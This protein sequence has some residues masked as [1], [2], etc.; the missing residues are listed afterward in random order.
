[1]SQDDLDTYTL[2]SQDDLESR[3]PELPEYRS[4]DCLPAVGSGAGGSDGVV[5]ETLYSI[6]RSQI[7]MSNQ[8]NSVGRAVA[9]LTPRTVII[10]YRTVPYCIHQ[11]P[12]TSIEH[13]F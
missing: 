11:K 8:L 9:S 10:L 5:V 7:Q 6:Q 3:L 13:A 2:L 1:M 12:F 4:L